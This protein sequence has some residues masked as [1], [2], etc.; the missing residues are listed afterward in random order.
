MNKYRFSKKESFLD[1]CVF[2]CRL[3]P[4]QGFLTDRVRLSQAI[5]GRWGLS[6]VASV[7]VF[8]E[9]DTHVDEG[10]TFLFRISALQAPLLH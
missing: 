3:A 5:Q 1:G 7:R 2:P 6:A 8:R 10:V 9:A 4:I